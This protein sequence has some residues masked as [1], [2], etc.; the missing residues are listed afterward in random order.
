MNIYFRYGL[1]FKNKLG[2]D[3]VFKEICILSKIKEC[4]L[5]MVI[6]LGYIIF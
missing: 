2:I 5:K 6:K 1:E 4:R 3:F